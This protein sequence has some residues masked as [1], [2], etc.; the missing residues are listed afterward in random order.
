MMKKEP[1]ISNKALKLQMLEEAEVIFESV[2]W[3]EKEIDAK[4]E[5]FE[6]AQ[7]N[8]LLE[9]EERL[10]KEIQSLVLKLRQEIKNMDIYLEKYNNV[11]QEAKSNEKVQKEKILSRLRKGQKKSAGSVSSR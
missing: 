8:F 2:N 5:E 3:M 11:I 7:T 10:E 9:D 4:L 6:A 1:I